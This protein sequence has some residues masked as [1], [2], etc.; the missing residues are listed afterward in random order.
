[1]QYT[2]IAFFSSFAG[3]VG[4]LTGASITTKSCV[5]LLFGWSTEEN[6]WMVSGGSP[7]WWNSLSR[8][9]FQSCQTNSSANNGIYCKIFGDCFRP[10]EIGGIRIF[11]MKIW[12]N[13]SR[14]EQSDLVPF[15]SNYSKNYKCRAKKYM[16]VGVLNVKGEQVPTPSQFLKFSD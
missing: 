1:M 7:K 6:E 8:R 4:W 14:G 15:F 5:S 3:L 2:T 12:R 10:M 13:M 9:L 16:Y 11:F